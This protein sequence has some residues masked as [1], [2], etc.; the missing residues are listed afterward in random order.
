MRFFTSRN[1]LIII[2]AIGLLSV[3][4]IR[5]YADERRG[6]SVDVDVRQSNDM[7]NQTSGDI[8]I[9][10][11]STLNAG[12]MIGGDTS[13]ST[14]TKNI[15]VA[16]P[17]LGD[18]DIADCLGST[19]WSLLVGGKQKLQ[20][21]HV[22]MA[23]F[24]LKAGRYDLAAQSLCNQPE[25]L[26]EYD[27][28]LAC[29]ADH[30]FSPPPMPAMAPEPAALEQHYEIEEQHDEDLAMVQAQLTEVSAQLVALEE[31]PPQQIVQQV[32]APPA[33]S[34]DR[35]DAVWLALKGKGDD[36]DE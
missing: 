4:A 14:S 24:Y 22:C 1:L 11:A 32:P 15:A 3:V 25:I 33:I 17:G 6:P 13:L 9:G 12:D 27:D 30:D 7:N 36:E 31:Q 34:E 28:E 19:Q 20:L 26:G 16:A 21:N 10:M 18:V 35:A 2:V 29:E 5:A 23:E 8:D